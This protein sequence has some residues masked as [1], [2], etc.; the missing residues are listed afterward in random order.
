M[1][2][3]YGRDVLKMIKKQKTDKTVKTVL[4]KIEPKSRFARLEK[5]NLNVSSLSFEIT[6][7]LLHP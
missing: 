7:N 2:H 4:S 1:K 3:Y 5:R 6:C